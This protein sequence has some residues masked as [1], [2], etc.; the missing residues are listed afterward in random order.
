MTIL[1]C[2]GVAGSGK[3]FAAEE[4]VD[5]LDDQGVRTVHAMSRFGPSVHKATRVRRK[6]T[7]AA[8]E[9][10]RDPL[11]IFSLLLAVKRT[12]QTSRRDALSLVSK[13][14]LL[15]AL[16]RPGRRGEALVIFDQGALMAIWSSAL[17]GLDHPCREL[18]Q[19]PSWGWVLPD[20]VLQVG[21]SAELIERHLGQRLRRQSRLETMGDVERETAI[22]EGQQLISE[23]VSW[24]EIGAVQSDQKCVT[25]WNDGTVDFNQKLRA[26]ASYL[27][28]NRCRA[29]LAEAAQGIEWTGVA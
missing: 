12:R 9:T 24:W 15:R 23:L 25:I 19:R 16:S 22:R 8:V 13:F 29:P 4:L 7:A 28:E 1:E 5:Y 20:Q 17:N 11:A 14:V 6:C 10:I 26:F 3:T 18:F 27:R 2:V 21:A